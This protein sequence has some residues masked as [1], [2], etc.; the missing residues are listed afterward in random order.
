MHS[1]TLERAGSPRKRTLSRGVSEDE[2]LRNIIKETESSTRRLTHSDSRG[3]TL[4]RR[5]GSQQSEEDQ[6]LMELPEMND[7]QASYDDV[8]QELRG[9]EL[10]RETLLF[11]VDIL[12]DTLEGAEEML[13]E[14]QREASHATMELER[15]REAKRKLEDIVSSLMQ[16][17]ERLKE[18]RNTISAVPVYTLV[19]EQE[20]EDEMARQQA[21]EMKIK[22]EAQ[23]Q[24]RDA[25]RDDDNSRQDAPLSIIR[26]DSESPGPN[27]GLSSE[28]STGGLLAS[29]FKKGRGEQ[30]SDSPT[31][32]SP[33]HVARL[34]SSEDVADGAQD[35]FTKFTKIVN[36]TFGP[37][38]LGSQTPGSNQEENGRD[39]SPDRN[40]DTDSI[41]AYEDACADMPELE[42]GDGPKLPHDEGSPVDDEGDPSNGNEPK[43]IK[44]PNES[45]ILS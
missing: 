4:K 28:T 26:L 9:L 14:A 8:L 40:N 43:S 1:G 11:Q 17:V 5:S 42:E 24:I 34:V 25:P 23:E 41:S 35:S 33:L 44:N 22:K 29:F 37:L 16:E 45:C 32:P 10:Q 3:G 38:A 12:Q 13:A 19:K 18:E 36:K 2:S 20:R 7:L 15:E 39:L 21:Q 30:P 6:E 27:N 31:R